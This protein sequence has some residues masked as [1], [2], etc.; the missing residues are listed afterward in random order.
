VKH[1]EG[2]DIHENKNLNAWNKI[3]A[4]CNIHNL[5]Q[6]FILM[7]DDI[8]LMQKQE[9]KYYHLGSLKQRVVDTRSKYN[10]SKYWF[11]MKRTSELFDH[12]LCF[13]PH[14]PIMY[15]KKKF[16]ALSDYYDVA[17][18]YLHRSLY[19]NHYN[20][21][22]QKIQDYKIYQASECYQY[23]KSTPFFL[24]SSDEFAGRPA[25]DNFLM[26]YNFMR[27]KSKYEKF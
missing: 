13:E 17:K 10:G 16:V 24:S 27:V 22:G 12:P 1:Y 15:N 3:I 8:Y 2:K 21:K 7:N 6:D 9:F 5:S 19:C 23:E 25:Y 18:V 26:G 14:Y 4:A 20:I 11:A